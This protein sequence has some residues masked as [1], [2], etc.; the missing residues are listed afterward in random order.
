MKLYTI[1]FA[2]KKARVFF[3]LLKEAKITL[4]LDTRLNNVSQLAGFTKKDDL[5][6]FT[7]EILKAKYKHSVE[8][9]PTKDILDDYKKGKI[10]WA[11]YEK[12]Y[13]ALLEKRNIKELYPK[14]AGNEIVCLL[15][16]EPTPEHCH[17]RLLAE[18]L[19]RHLENIQIVHL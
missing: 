16:S 8:C 11:E 7:K 9:A 14:L 10:T 3:P 2:Q 15:C 12:K 19:Q 13:N 5:E 6:Y 1:G 4:L 17:R 18:Y